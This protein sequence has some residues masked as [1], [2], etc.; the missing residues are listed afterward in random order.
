MLDSLSSSIVYSNVRSVK[1][2]AT[3]PRCPKVYVGEGIIQTNVDR[4]IRYLKQAAP[5]VC[6]MRVH[7]RGSRHVVEGDVFLGPIL[8]FMRFLITNVAKSKLGIG[9]YRGAV[10]YYVDLRSINNVGPLTHIC[11][12]A[13]N[14][15]WMFELT[16]KSSETLQVLE[17]DYVLGGADLCSLI[18]DGKGNHVVYPNMRQLFIGTDG[19]NSRDT[20]IYS[21]PGTVPFPALQQFN[22]LDQY[23]FGDDVVF[24]D[25]QDTLKDLRLKL[26]TE[27]VTQLISSKVFS[28]SSHPNLKRVKICLDLNEEDDYDREAQA[29]LVYEISKNAWDL[30]LDIVYDRHTQPGVLTPSLLYG[31]QQLRKLRF[32]EYSLRITEI[33]QLLESLPDLVEFGTK[34]KPMDDTQQPQT[35]IDEHYPLGTSLGK[36]D[37]KMV[38]LDHHSNEPKPL[39]VV[40][41]L[42]PNIVTVQRSIFHNPIEVQRVMVKELCRLGYLQYV[43]RFK[44]LKIMAGEGY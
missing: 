28:T 29:K 25:N 9:I 27:T 34:F 37:A 6:D 4:I 38:D 3:A 31:Q 20:S 10:D 1:L 33:I 24:R 15:N 36:L 19:C 17:L 11:I 2:Y 22:C 18:M 21:F 39:V 7:I 14:D 26:K 12:M 23:P 35:L 40:I 32:N 44:A 30:A 43:T 5:N 42:C 41:L 13:W 8:E 16:R